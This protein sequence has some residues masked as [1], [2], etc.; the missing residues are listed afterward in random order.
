MF[1]QSKQVDARP[2]DDGTWARFAMPTF[3][4]H[5]VCSEALWPSKPN[6]IPGNL[7]H[8]SPS[9]AAVENTLGRRTSRAI[10]LGARD[11]AAIREALNQGQSVVLCVPVYRNSYRNPA[12]DSFGIIP[13]PIPNS[14][15]EGGHAMCAVGYGYDADDISGGWYFIVKNSWGLG[16]AAQSVIEPGY[17]TIP[18]RYVEKYGWGGRYTLAL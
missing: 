13:I 2:N 11:T 16:W 1:Y 6:V 17:G 5:G 4:E 3:V 15:L 14:P 18:F 8:G 12:T 10:D 7:T 9:A